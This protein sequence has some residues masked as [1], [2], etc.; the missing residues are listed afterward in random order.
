MTELMARISQQGGVEL[1]DEKGI[2]VNGVPPMIAAEAAYLA[3]GIL[4]CAAALFGTRPAKA[5]QIIGDAH[6]PIMKWRTTTS[7]ITDEPVMI[8]AHPSGIELTFVMPPQVAIELG[9]ALVA[10]GQ[11]NPP[12]AGRSGTVH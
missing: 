12:P 6:F 3:R 10:Q 9:T 8:L 5:G 1:V 7:N 4:A 11:K 2:A